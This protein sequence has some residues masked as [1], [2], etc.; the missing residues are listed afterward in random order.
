MNRIIIAFFLL[1]FYTHFSFAQNGKNATK[2]NSNINSESDE[3]Y[4]LISNDGKKLFF[5]RSNFKDNVGGEK[6]GQD[7]WISEKQSDGSWGKAFNPGKP[8]NTKGHNSIGGINSSNQ[9]V[10]ASNQYNK[11]AGGIASFSCFDSKFSEE[12]LIWDGNELNS[13]GFFSFF[14]NPKET[15]MLLSYSTS[16]GGSEDLYV[17]LKKD[18]DWGSAMISGIVAGVVFAI[19]RSNFTG[20]AS[21]IVPGLA[22]AFFIQNKNFR[23]SWFQKA[24]AI[25]LMFIIGMFNK[26]LVE[27]LKQFMK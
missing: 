25:G 7:I 24:F 10:F 11:M 26:E 1:H 22:L 2:L 16:K 3:L 21:L 20:A 18:G 13:D 5:V 6:S 17:S 9:K 23:F 27:L 8:L 12:K 19:A 4:P 14:V 15:I